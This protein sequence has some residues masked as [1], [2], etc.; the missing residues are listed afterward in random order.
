[1]HF[2]LKKA[3]V[4]PD[5]LNNRQTR[6]SIL[7]YYRILVAIRE[8]LQDEMLGFLDQKIPP[9]AF[10]LFCEAAT[11]Y[12]DFKSLMK[13]VNDFYDILLYKLCWVM[14][15]DPNLKL[16]SIL[17]KFQK[18]FA[19]Y[20][21]FIIEFLMITPYRAGGWLIG[22]NFKIRSVHFT[23]S[24]PEIIEKYNYLFGSQIFFEA[25]QN[26]FV[27]DSDILSQPVVRNRR[28][29]F[30]F[31]RSSLSWFLLNPGVPPYTRR[32]RQ[33][34]M[35]KDIS[36]GFPNFEKIA[37]G[38]NI[39][40][41]HLWRKLNYEGTSYQ[42]IKNQLRR[43]MAIHFLSNTQLSISEIAYKIGYTAERPFYKMF[44]QWTGIPP[45]QYRRMVQNCYK[46]T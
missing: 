40:H 20:K 18:D 6:I 45:R 33:K 36:R 3:G 24:K 21:K 7:I 16:T 27:F 30:K 26:M 4:P 19:Q 2:L 34:L 37:R 32:V 31:L 42:Q 12:P 29:A 17:L 11:G 5:L 46:K 35:E 15:T 1:M 38:L 22:E 8:H 41:Q 13:F 39:S 10:P 28:E 44:N 43:D 9:K 14:K 25:E 23:F